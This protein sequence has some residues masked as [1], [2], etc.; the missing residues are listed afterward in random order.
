[1]NM[2]N[3]TQSPPTPSEQADHLIR[4]LAES[5]RKDR[6]QEIGF[7]LNDAFGRRIGASNGEVY[8]E[9]LRDVVEQGLLSIRG[10]GRFITPNEISGRGVDGLLTVEGWRYYEKL[11]KG[12]ISGNRGFMAMK[13]EN[14]FL[15][16]VV[17]KHFKPA[18][19][20]AG[21]EL[22][23]LDD[24]PAAGLIDDRMLVAIRTSAFVVADLSDDNLGAY[25][26]AG[27]AS[28]LGKPIFFT[29]E[30]KKWERQKTHFDTNHH[31]TIPW[32]YK[33]PAEAAEHLKAAIR[34]TFPDNAKMSDE[35]E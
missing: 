7:H 4:L 8:R 31:Y 30:R 18:A 9:I 29:C 28:G 25:F 17:D 23:A 14:K 34:N 32:D 13:F 15:R 6:Y 33:K 26:E 20:N 24:Q 19:K 11:L 12:K 27:F 35:E 3:P 1:M 21:Y 2:P 10:E 22:A 5:E 16:R